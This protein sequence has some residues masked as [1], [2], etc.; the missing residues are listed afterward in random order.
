MCEISLALKLWYNTM[1][2]I[3][4]EKHDPSIIWALSRDILA[5]HKIMNL[6][7]HICREERRL[8]GQ[9]HCDL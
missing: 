3:E 2:V 1:C 6:Y 5:I 8:T 7:E 4:K 9:G